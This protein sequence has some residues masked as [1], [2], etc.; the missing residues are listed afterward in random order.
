MHP[1]PAPTGRPRATLPTTVRIIPPGPGP[2]PTR[3]SGSCELALRRF[4]S[5]PRPA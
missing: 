5:Q 1:R 4:G 3:C 2:A